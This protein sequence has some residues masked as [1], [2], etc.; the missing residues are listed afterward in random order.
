MTIMIQF[1]VIALMAAALLGALWWRDRRRLAG[2]AA[3]MWL[4]YFLWEQALS[5]GYGCDP[6]CNIRVDLLV[7]YP[8]LAVAS[9]TVLWRS[10]RGGSDA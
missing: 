5:L 10:L 7:I 2:L 8:I 3:L 4:A 9:L 1:P 6:D